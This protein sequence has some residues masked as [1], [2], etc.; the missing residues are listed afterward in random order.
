[1]LTVHAVCYNEARML[2]YFLRHYQ[3]IASRIVIHDNES[4][5]DSVKIARGAGAEVLSFN[6]NGQLDELTLVGVR[7]DCWKTKPDTGWVAVVDVDEFL[8]H[9][10]V[11]S[12]TDDCERRGITVVVPQ[13]FQML[14][15]T[16]PDDYTLPITDQVRHGTPY[17]PFCKPVLFNAS[18]ITS[19][20][21]GPG[22]HRAAPE[23]DVHPDTSGDL[24]LLHYRWLGL[25]WMWERNSER[26]ARR[27][28]AMQQVGQGREY[29]DSRA[30]LQTTYRQLRK[31]SINVFSG[32]HHPSYVRRYAKARRTRLTNQ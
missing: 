32:D 27:S 23:G 18:H 15:D 3:P 30:R 22:S 14:S 1:M 25:D 29:A 2:P 10:D 11:Q 26:L 6:T 28:E 21:F 13:G 9:P 19:M 24:K 17:K 8:Y 7:N 20:N 4:T 31:R 16:F 5:D 12:F